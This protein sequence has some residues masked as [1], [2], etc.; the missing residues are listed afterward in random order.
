MQALTDAEGRTW[1]VEVSGSRPGNHTDRLPLRPEEHTEVHL[2]CTSGTDRFGVWVD[3]SWRDLPD[4]EK[5][6]RIVHARA[7]QKEGEEEH[8]DVS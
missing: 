7:A 1:F 2:V 5:W 6:E 8:G 3:R 4:L